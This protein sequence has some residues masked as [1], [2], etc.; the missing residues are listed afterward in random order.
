MITRHDYTLSKSRA[1][2]LNG[3]TVA[4]LRGTLLDIRRKASGLLHVPPAIALALDLLNQ[5]EGFGAT[6][7]CVTVTDTG[8][9][10]Y[11]ALGDFRAGGF[12]IQRGGFEPQLACR[13]SA[14]TSDLK[15]AS[16]ALRAGEV[17][18]RPAQP[19]LF[20]LDA[21]KGGVLR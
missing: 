17:K 7:L 3:R 13:L 14:F 6:D 15:I 9:K 18:F 2:R 21:F 19:P 10:Y 8:E 11:I 5:A 1:I 4:V 16:K 12:R 20:A